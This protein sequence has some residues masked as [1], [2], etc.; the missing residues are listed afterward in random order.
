M[1]SVKIEMDRQVMVRQIA[2]ERED[3]N[4]QD[5]PLLSKSH[6][7]TKEQNGNNNS[8][9]KARIT[10]NEARRLREADMEAVKKVLDTLGQILRKKQFDGFQPVIYKDMDTD[11]EESFLHLIFWKSSLGSGS[12]SAMYKNAG[13]AVV[14]A[15]E[16]LAKAD[17]E[18]AGRVKMLVN[19]RDG[20]GRTVL[21]HAT[22]K[23][24]RRMVARLLALDADLCI[25][26]VLGEL[27]VARINPSTLERFLD[28]K[29]FPR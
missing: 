28:S 9:P 25:G 10:F 16:K 21:H 11:S 20:Q 23:W 1:D 22:L 4:D 18:V 8:S 14:D 15:L 27:P 29:W 26:D 13:E 6:D 19:L 2:I 3:D 12:T 24:G 17:E 7:K 5:I